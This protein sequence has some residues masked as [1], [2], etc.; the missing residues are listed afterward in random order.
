MAKSDE[1]PLDGVLNEIQ[2]F[3]QKAQ[4]VAG[5]PI[6][7]DNITPEVEQRLSKLENAMATYLDKLRSEAVENN[8]DLKKMEEGTMKMPEGLTKKQQTFW[9][10]AAKLRWD[11]EGM[12][13]ALNRANNSMKESHVIEKTPGG[14]KR[15]VIKRKSKFKKMGGDTWKKM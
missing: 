8:I 7:P 1:N 12:R 4:E 2:N 11:A 3:L 6:N 15:A 10:K 13:F 14:K 9:V 5:K